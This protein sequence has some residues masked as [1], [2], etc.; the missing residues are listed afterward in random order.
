MLPA[1]RVG[2][3]H[4]LVIYAKRILER[5]AHQHRYMR[6]ELPAELV[7]SCF[8]L[9]DKIIQSK[10]QSGALSHGSSHG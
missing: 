2:L 10:R 8:A 1:H 5:V 7:D 9:I 3:A 6:T 4:K